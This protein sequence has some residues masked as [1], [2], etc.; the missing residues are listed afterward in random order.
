MQ[1]NISII[2]QF[3]SAEQ[4]LRPKQV[5]ISHAIV[6]LKGRFNCF[7]YRSLILCPFSPRE[8]DKTWFMLI[9]IHS[10]TTLSSL[11]FL[12]TEDTF[13]FQLP[14]HACAILPSFALD[15]AHVEFRVFVDIQSSYVSLI[16]KR[17]RAVTK[18]FYERNFFVSLLSQNKIFVIIGHSQ[19]TETLQSFSIIAY[20]LFES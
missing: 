2:I 7:F 20:S 9:D 12:L 14:E 4:K 19:A 3:H 8:S 5:Q 13:C 10:N 17:N 11:M 15:T 1:K 18:N 6:T 16:Q